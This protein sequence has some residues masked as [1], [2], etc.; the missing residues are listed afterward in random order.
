[1]KLTLN[2]PASP[3]R[4]ADCTVEFFDA[5]EEPRGRFRQIG[6]IYFHD[7]GF[8]LNCKRP[9]ILR[10]LEEE[11]CKAGADAVDIYRESYPNAWTTCYRVKAHLL[12]RID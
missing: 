4:P 8:S 11:A 3:K 5:H 2:Q 12:E 7:T 10:R 1:M 9:Q 6:H